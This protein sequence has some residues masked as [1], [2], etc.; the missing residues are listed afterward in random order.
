[1]LLDISRAR[2]VYGWEPAV[3]LPEGLR[4]EYDWARAHPERWQAIRYTVT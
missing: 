2:Q 4:R 3:A 1:M